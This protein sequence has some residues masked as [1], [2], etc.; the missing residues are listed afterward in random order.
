[1]PTE[2]KIQTF[3]HK[4]EEGRWAKWLQLSVLVMAVVAV[5][6]LWL[7]GDNGFKGFAQPHAFEQAEIAREIARGNG[8][9][10][11]LFRPAALFQFNQRAEKMRQKGVNPG[12]FPVDRTPD[13]YHAPLWSVTLAPFLWL[14]RNNWKMTEKDVLYRA[15][16]IVASVATLFFLLAVVVNYFLARR[17]FDHRLAIL[18]TGLILVSDRLWRYSMTGLPQMLMLFLFSCG[19]YAL[20]RAVE[21]YSSR[22]AGLEDADPSATDGEPD[23]SPEHVETTAPTG[24]AALPAPGPLHRFFQSP[25][26][27]IMTAAVFFSLL[28]LTHALTIWILAGVLVFCVCYFQPRGLYAGIMLAI[29]ALSYTPWLV[30]NYRAC[31][32]PFGVSWYSGLYQIRGTE[33]AIMRSMDPPLQGVSPSNFRRKI[34]GQTQNQFD[35]IYARLGGVVAAPF[36]FIA[37]LHLF[38]RRSTSHF[39]WGILLAWL[40]AV[41]GMSVFGLEND[42]YP[43]NDLHLLFIPLMT[44]YGLAFVMV[45]WSRLEIRIKLV[46]AAFLIMLFVVSGYT[47]FFTALDLLGRPA[48]R[49]QWPPYVPPYVAILS[50]WTDERE[51]IMSDM[52]WAVAWYADRRS[53][54]LPSSV[55]SYLELNDWDVLQGQIVG[56]HLTPVSGNGA[57]LG[58]IVKGDYKEW[59]PFIMR[60]ANLRSFPL[61][62]VQP[63]PFE[64]M[65]VFYADRDRWSLRED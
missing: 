22:R 4:L 55:G 50:N 58:D 28:A 20:L 26:V 27:W 15:D 6:Y 41:F 23:L 24:A 34:I 21:C 46:Q 43:S 52:P 59:A 30:R 38:R 54:W 2:T 12:S 53:L 65:C 36:F 29:F 32:H 7:L 11:K 1:M 63:L 48:S 62:A 44:F 45:L 60:T 37:L 14:D 49:V 13:T 16:R 51:I 39:R 17:L 25:L 3:I 64:N 8:F 31:G 5:S 9:T 33:S 56:L 57:F 47:F 18:A 42:S 10:T 35:N 40:T 19:M 61:K